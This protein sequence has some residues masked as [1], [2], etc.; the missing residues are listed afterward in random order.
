MSMIHR[1]RNNNKWDQIIVSYLG[2]IDRNRRI[3]NGLPIIIRSYCDYGSIWD[4]LK[5]NVPMFEWRNC[6][7]NYYDVF[8]VDID[9]SQKE[10]AKAWRETS[11]ICHPDKRRLSEENSSHRIQSFLNKAYKVLSRKSHDI[12]RE[13]RGRG[14]EDIHWSGTTRQKYTD[15][16]GWLRCPATLCRKFN[17]VNY[18][19]Y[20][21]PCV[22][23]C[24]FDGKPECRFCRT[25]MGIFCE[26]RFCSDQR[27]NSIN[28]AIAVL[29][30]QDN[31][32]LSIE[33]NLALNMPAQ[34]EQDNGVLSIEHNLLSIE[35]NNGVLSIEQ[36]NETKD[37]N[38]DDIEL[39]FELRDIEFQILK[40]ENEQL[41]RQNGRLQE[42]N[43][44]LFEYGCLMEENEQ[45]RR[46]NGRLEKENERLRRVEAE[47]ERLRSYMHIKYPM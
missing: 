42:E 26:C 24:R 33:Q 20:M 1:L 27:R 29:I 17:K 16:R 36:N 40:E 43:E 25:E 6:E 44:M 13:W 28:F 10:I 45:L 31:G 18:M 8:A 5:D 37:E 23:D 34:I 38:D 11:L 22:Y 9:A 46:Q 4:D 19:F 3:E 2:D 21:R 32:V 41:R 39:Q 15:F 47:N 12:G 14:E 30:E 35:Q 7:Y